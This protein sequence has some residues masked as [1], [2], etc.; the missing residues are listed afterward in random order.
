MSNTYYKPGTWNCIC[1]V[2]GRKVKS[3]ELRKRWDGFMVCA[4]DWEPRHPLDFIR[5]RGELLTVPYTRPES[6]DSFIDGPQCTIESRQGVAGVGTAGCAMAGY[7][8][9]Q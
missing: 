1:D 3:D 8:I 7:F 2:C 9:P 6:T 4:E 5:V